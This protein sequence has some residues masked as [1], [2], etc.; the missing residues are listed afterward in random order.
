MFNAEYIFLSGDSTEEHCNLNTATDKASMAPSDN[1]KNAHLSKPS[2][3]RAGSNLSKNKYTK[4]NTEKGSDRSANLGNNYDGKQPPFPPFRL[5]QFDC[6]R[7]P[8]EEINGED[9]HFFCRDAYDDDFPGY[10]DET[11]R[12]SPSVMT[13]PGKHATPRHT[14]LVPKE[15][16]RSLAGLSNLG[17][18]FCPLHT[19]S[20]LEAAEDLDFSDYEDI[21]AFSDIPTALLIS[22]VH[23]DEFL[24]KAMKKEQQI[25]AMKHIQRGLMEG[26][27]LT[28]L[29]KDCSENIGGCAHEEKDKPK[30]NTDRV[31]EVKNGCT[32]FGKLPQDGSLS[33]NSK[34][35]AKFDKASVD[36]TLQV[37]NTVGQ[38]NANHTSNAFSVGEA[39]KDTYEKPSQIEIDDIR[40]KRLQKFQKQQNSNQNVDTKNKHDNRDVTTNVARDKVVKSKVFKKSMQPLLREHEQ[41]SQVLESKTD[42]SEHIGKPHPLMP[43]TDAQTDCN[44]LKESSIDHENEDMPVAMKFFRR[45]RVTEQIFIERFQPEVII[46]THD[47]KNNML[48]FEIGNEKKSA[49]ETDICETKQTE[50]NSSLD[51]TTSSTKTF[52]SNGQPA[53][54]QKPVNKYIGKNPPQKRTTCVDTTEEYHLFQPAHSSDRKRD[55]YLHRRRSK[56]ESE[57]DGLSVI[58]KGKQKKNK[59]M[60]LNQK[61]KG[62]ESSKQNSD[63]HVEKTSSE[64]PGTTLAKINESDPLFQEAKR[65]HLAFQQLKYR[66]NDALRCSCKVYY[67]YIKIFVVVNCR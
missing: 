64:T 28:A 58:D 30:P 53:G 63:T 22:N 32:L 25:T 13:Y 47:E 12:L 42:A 10:N 51:N 9:E 60:F 62:I 54:F 14:D 46:P 35:D 31:K 66:P 38:G 52:K 8:Q 1:S 11:D 33:N 27:G 65:I 21:P 59:N 20:A 26:E 57:A 3:V 19:T 29:T 23:S 48:H 16:L 49:K 34:A 15:Q 50:Q 67:V 18:G 40:Q 41:V 17:L 36:A 4:V 37:T 55:S 45:Q 24:R 6:Y 61:S 7:T 43:N 44:N 39:N 5:R 56:E 2:E